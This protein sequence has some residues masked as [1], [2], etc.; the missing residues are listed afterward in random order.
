VIVA[1]SLAAAWSDNPYF[2]GHI[3]V[4]V[5]VVVQTFVDNLVVVAAPVAGEYK[6]RQTDR[7]RTQSHPPSF[8]ISEDF[9]FKFWHLSIFC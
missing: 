5:V 7:W 6:N 2:V 9:Y 4:A 3:V 8:G 1:S